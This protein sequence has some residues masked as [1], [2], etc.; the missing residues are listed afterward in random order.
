MKKSLEKIKYSHQVLKDARRIGLETQK[1]YLFLDIFLTIFVEAVAFVNSV[2]LIKYVLDGIQNGVE[3]WNC[4][5][6]LCVIIVINLASI[7]ARTVRDHILRTEHLLKLA[8]KISY[9]FFQKTGRLSYYEQ[10]NSNSKDIIHF[11]YKNAAMIIYNSE[12][13]ISTYVGYAVIFLF[14]FVATVYYG[15]C[16]GF[17]FLVIFLIIA[18]IMQKNGI[19]INEIDFKHFLIQNGLN[20]KFR[21]YKDNIF[22]SKQMN[23]VFKVD[24]A[25]DFFFNKYEE[26]IDEQTRNR[27]EQNRETFWLKILKNHFFD[28]LYHIVYF[29]S[30]S[31]KLIIANSMTVGSFWACYRACFSV[32][33]S[34]IFDFFSKMHHAVQYIE[35][36]NAFFKMPEENSAADR[37]LDY[38][39][40][41]EIKFDH[42]SFSYPG[43]R[44]RVLKDINISI[45]KGTNIVVLGE[46][47]AGKSTIILLL[48][49]LLKPTEGKVTLNGIDIEEY[50]LREYRNFFNIMFQDFKIYPYSLG[51]NV[52]LKNEYEAER[53]K[54]YDCLDKAG[55]KRVNDVMNRGIDTPLTKLFDEN[56]YV[57]SGGEIGKIGFAQQLMN[58][59]GIYV[60][61]EYD[62]S[63]DPLSE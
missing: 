48:F 6:I 53:S 36:Y 28:F 34:N 17:L 27:M 58:E 59:M 8:K 24:E 52:S 50:D 38:K 14:N 62:S 3:F 20:R 10:F 43:Q 5:P 44:K 22:F 60:F 13:L 54:I 4:I 25:F 33:R 16:V 11:M 51:A 12:L 63:I 61:D 32:F 46:N 18:L 40:D 1:S 49:R 30:F 21:Y 9:D 56:G 37:K 23:Q 7:I 31:Y 55:L 26:L 41:F 39:E 47:G 2:F 35:Q 15:G 45:K 57:P 29:A 19:K 42:V